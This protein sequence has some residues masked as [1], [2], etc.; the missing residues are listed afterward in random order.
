[1]DAFYSNPFF[2][3]VERRE[4]IGDFLV[5]VTQPVVMTLEQLIRCELYRWDLNTVTLLFYY[6]CLL[7]KDLHAGNYVYGDICAA[8]VMLSPTMQPYLTDMHKAVEANLNHN[9][10]FK[11]P[12]AATDMLSDDEVTVSTAIV[13][14]GKMHDV[15]KVEVLPATH[16]TQ[17]LLRQELQ[18]LGLLLLQQI[19]GVNG[20]VFMNKA[21]E[22]DLNRHLSI[23]KGNSATI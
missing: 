22:Q 12:E 20:H 19:F 17:L 9:S 18:G 21:T 3:K 23:V 15:S 6:V 2:M 4:K 7:I 14:T 16:D 13:K 8:N 10:I 5:I 11:P 1:M